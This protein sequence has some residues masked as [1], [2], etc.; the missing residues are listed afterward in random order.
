VKLRQDAGELVLVEIDGLGMLLGEIR[1]NRQT[2]TVL[3]A[4]ERAAFFDFYFPC[5]V[6]FDQQTGPVVRPHVLAALTTSSVRVQRSRISCFVLEDDLSP[7]LVE[8]YRR[9]LDAILGR[10][11]LAPRSRGGGEGKGPD[12]SGPGGGPRIV[13]L[14]KRDEKG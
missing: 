12:R 11:G 5:A 10:Q 7:Q 2:E 8:Q 6:V 13:D 4:M 1:Y 3:F 9:L 14:R